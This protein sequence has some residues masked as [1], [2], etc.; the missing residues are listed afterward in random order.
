[1]KTLIII[2]AYNEEDN[3]L[4]LVK[5]VNDYKYDYLV[6]NDHSTDNTRKILDENSINHIDL[7]INLGLAGVTRAGFKYACENDYDCCICID[8]DGQHMPEYIINLINEVE[9]GNDYV[10]GSRFVNKKKPV[11]LRMLGSRL[12]CMLIKLKSGQ[13]V[14]DPTSGMRALGKNVIK[15]FAGSMNFHAEPDA[16]CYLIRKK[17]KVKEVQVKMKER[18]A[19]VSYFQSPFKSIYF[20]L[21]VILSIVFVQ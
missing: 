6:I 21:N 16:M 14:Y 10:V 18:E 19:G 4:P 12:L 15:E 9:N 1:M 20:M 13:T 8:G 3:I 5:L 17:Y 2:P 7:P 11:S